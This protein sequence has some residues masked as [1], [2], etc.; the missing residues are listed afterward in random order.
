MC[1]HRTLGTR[2]TWFL[3]ALHCSICVTSA[4]I[5]LRVH[6]QMLWCYSCGKMVWQALCDLSMS[7]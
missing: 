2:N 1:Q 3:N 6:R 4:L 5:S 7:A